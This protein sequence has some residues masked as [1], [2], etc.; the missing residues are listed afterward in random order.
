MGKSSDNQ[1]EGLFV[2]VRLENFSNSRDRFSERDSDKGGRSQSNSKNNVKCYY[3]KRFRHYKSE[4]PKLKNKEEGD[5]PSFSSVADVVEENYEDSEFVLAVTVSNGRFNDKWV[6]DTACTFHIS[7]KRDWLT[8]YESVNCGTVLMGND[9]AC[10]IVGIG[11]IRIKMHDK[12]VRTLTNVRHI[13]DLKKNLISLGT[14]D[15][16]G[17]K[18]SDEGEVIRVSNGSLVVMEGNKVDDLYFLQGSTVIGLDVVSSS[19]NL[20]SNTT[21]L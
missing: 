3:C 15:S 2:K 8:T 16:L 20:E 13:P 14:L 5:E 18:Y 7:P 10:Q 19:D 6:L 21:R 12:I 17:Y 4:C 11:T 9:V 1:A